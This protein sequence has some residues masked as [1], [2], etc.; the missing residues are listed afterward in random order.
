[1]TGS[2]KTAVNKVFPARF[3]TKSAKESSHLIYLAQRHVH[4][5]ADPYQR[6]LWQISEFS[7]DILQYGNQLTTVPVVPRYYRID[8][9]T[10]IH[11]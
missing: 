3:Q 1:M 5:L 6:I 8:F 4:T 2:S 9:V 7:L 11:S 10:I